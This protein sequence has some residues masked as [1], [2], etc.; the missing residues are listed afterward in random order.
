MADKIIERVDE[1][2]RGFVKRLL[3]TS[4]AAPL[5]ATF[6]LGALSS[7]MANAQVVSNATDQFCRP[8]LEAAFD[9]EGPAGTGRCITVDYNTD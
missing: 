1:N 6:S 2:R 8:D 7:S 4:F 9:F 3:G 5:I